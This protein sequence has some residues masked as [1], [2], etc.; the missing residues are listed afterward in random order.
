[1]RYQ[2]GVLKVSGRSL[3]VMI[4]ILPFWQVRVTL[5]MKDEVQV[6]VIGGGRVTA[7]TAAGHASHVLLL[8]HVQRVVEAPPAAPN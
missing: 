5:E 2:T 7:L 6:A 4:T 3:S 8:V 1:M